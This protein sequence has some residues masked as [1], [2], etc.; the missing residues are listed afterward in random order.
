MVFGRTWASKWEGCLQQLHGGETINTP[1][2][3]FGL[4][5]NLQAAAWGAAAGLVRVCTH[6]LRLARATHAFL[7][8][9]VSCEYPTIAK[10]TKG[11]QH[12]PSRPN[13]ERGTNT[14]YPDLKLAIVEL[15]G[16]CFFLEM[17]FEFLI[18]KTFEKWQSVTAKSILIGSPLE[19]L[20]KKIF[21]P[22]TLRDGFYNTF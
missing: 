17:S 4:C 22:T 9:N 10:N 1:G 11:K 2:A 15:F 8:G 7:L 19:E 21:H 12:R 13:L 14:R 3:V 6:G 5:P 18:L 16:G 20:P